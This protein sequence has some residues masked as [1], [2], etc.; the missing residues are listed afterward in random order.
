[1]AYN[2]E[3]DVGMI[4]WVMAAFLVICGLSYWVGPIPEQKCLEWG[5]WKEGWQ[6]GQGPKGISVR[7]R[8]HKC[9]KWDESWR[10]R[11]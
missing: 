11:H 1:M 5:E 6:R 3:L 4:Y 9:L 2:K 10:E 7:V 8:Y